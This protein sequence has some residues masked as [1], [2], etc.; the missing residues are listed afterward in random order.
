[1]AVFGTKMSFCRKDFCVG[2]P[3]W[4]KIDAHDRREPTVGGHLVGRALGRRVD[5]DAVDHVAE[6]RLGQEVS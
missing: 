4:E 2:S 1:V 3:D 5:N 6:R